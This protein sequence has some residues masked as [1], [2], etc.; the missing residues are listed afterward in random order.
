MLGPDQTGIQ[1]PDLIVSA[2][3]S[4]VGKALAK[5]PSGAP[6]ASSGRE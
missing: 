3:S 1:V 2:R 4:L 5:P 6:V